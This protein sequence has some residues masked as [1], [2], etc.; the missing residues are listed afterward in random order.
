M[1]A[2][3]RPHEGGSPLEAVMRWLAAGATRWPRAVVGWAVTL[4]VLAV[5]VTTFRLGFKTSRLDLLNPRSAY[6]QRWLA[7]LDE[8]GE[9]DDVLVV[10]DGPS[11]TEVTA[12]IDDL[13]DRL[14]CES[15]LFF[16]LLYRPDFATARSKG[17]HHLPPETL[18]R[19]ERRLAEIEPVLAGQWQGLGV[20]ALLRAA[21]ERTQFAARPLQPSDAFASP[22]AAALAD[23][24][25]NELTVLLVGMTAAL[26]DAKYQSPWPTLLSPHELPKFDDERLLADDG[27]LGFLLV[28]LRKDESQFTGNAPA[29]GRLRA[30]VADA[31][32]LHGRVRIGLTG[33]PVLENDEMQSS[34]KDMMRASIMSLFGV[35]ALF[36]AGFGGWRYPALCVLT[37]LIGMAWSFAYV[38]LAVGHLNILSVSFGVIL[39]GLGIDFGIHFVAGY[40][41]R[42]PNAADSRVALIDTAGGVGPG[43]ITG[44]V[45]TA[46]A[47]FTAALTQFTGVAEL[48][49]IAGGGI[50]LCVLAAVVVLPAMMQWMDRNREASRLPAILPIGDLFQPLQKHPAVSLMIGMAPVVLLA[51]GIFWLEFDHN[52]LNLQSPRLE[53]VR[54]EHELIERADQSVWFA[55]SMARD[56]EEVQRRKAAF[57]KL[58]T[59][60]RVEEVASLAA[61]DV[62]TKMSAIQRI[63]RRLASLPDDSPAIEKPSAAGLRAIAEELRG[64]L[65]RFAGQ[66]EQTSRDGSAF[67]GADSETSTDPTLGGLKSAEAAADALVARLHSMPAE[68]V[69]SRIA[70]FQQRAAS[71]LLDGLRQMRAAANPDPPA[72]ADLPES[73]AHRFV[74]KNGTHLLRIYAA[75][76]VWDMDRLTEFVRDIESV[77]PRVTGHPVQTY[78][79]SRQMQ[80]S[81]VHAAIYALLAVGITLMLDFRSIRSSLLAM[82]PVSLGM[83]QLFG[84]LGIMGMPLNPANLIVLPLI[85]GIGIDDGVHVVHEFRNQKGRYRLGNATATA[86]VITSATTM[87]GFGCMMFAEHRGIRSLGQVLTLG[88]F[89][90]LVT[91]LVVL[92]AILRLLTSR[93]EDGSDAEPVDSTSQVDDENQPRVEESS[94]IRERIQPRRVSR[95]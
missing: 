49:V 77:D 8:F 89:C 51:G 1:G 78:Y 52:L 15:N 93:R 54:L 58:P 63:S 60:D 72:L 3:R 36:M 2:D 24:S 88:V 75:G 91:S 66:L 6:N 34:Q 33:M 45:T 11:S 42:R 38:T 5:L 79:A 94:N 82:I 23:N 17:L 12:A 71:E 40:L 10:V 26:H 64:R 87:I 61:A 47:F 14:T 39:I 55:L 67:D 70:E 9:D 69:E 56:V 85:L 81:Y 16:D 76:N 35:A 31:S 57:A 41:Q 68:Q 84:L 7:Y 37:L 74:G 65:N 53:S 92:P 32:R 73:I 46:I 43:I 86:I 19:I 83:I 50:L 90:C 25:F 30:I 27:R 62:P 4:A 28:K 13:G 95:S 29:L 21:V 44:G 20:A 18:A 80:R 48:G 59:V 22:D